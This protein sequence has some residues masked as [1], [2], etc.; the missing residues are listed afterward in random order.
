MFNKWRIKGWNKT[1]FVSL[2]LWENTIWIIFHHIIETFTSCKHVSGTGSHYSDTLS[3]RVQVV[4]M[5]IISFRPNWSRLPEEEETGASSLP[6]PHGNKH[7][8]NISVV[9]DERSSEDVCRLAQIQFITQS[10]YST[11][12]KS[13]FKEFGGGKWRETWKRQNWGKETK[14][15]RLS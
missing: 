12:T 4:P 8:L 3:A 15:R 10:G 7:T 14:T 13:R 9:S 1:L 2:L 11:A 5:W 6:V